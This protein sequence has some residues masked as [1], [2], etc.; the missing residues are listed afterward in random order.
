M[1]REPLTFDWTCNLQNGDTISYT[2]SY[3]GLAREQSFVYWDFKQKCHMKGPGEILKRQH[4]MPFVS[5][6]LP[7][8]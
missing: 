4:E 5:N 8:V 1:V 2:L 6:L 3:L 7:E